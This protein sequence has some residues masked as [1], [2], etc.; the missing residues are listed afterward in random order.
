MI[1]ASSKLT[2]ADADPVP[3]TPKAA[4]QTI[5]QH[6]LSLKGD[7]IFDFGNTFIG[8]ALLS[9]G[10]T[11]SESDDPSSDLRLEAGIQL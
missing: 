2:W 11:L 10:G 4:R 3:T 7:R 6:K 5:T 8:G 9:T 1:G